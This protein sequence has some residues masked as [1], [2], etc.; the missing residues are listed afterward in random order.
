[1]KLYLAGGALALSLAMPLAAQAPQGPISRA[2]FMAQSK[3][4]FTALD[5]N[6]DGAITKDEVVAG[7]TK[8][9]R[10]APPPE[11]VDRL[12]AAI[13]TDSDGKATAGEVEKHAVERFDK[14]DTDH[15]GTLTAEE[16]AASQ[17]AMMAAQKPQ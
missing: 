10:S 9:F 7:M 13:D 1:M 11:I 12:F 8:M 4:Q 14:A 5:A 17:K 16:I 3:A 2:D 15:D 6:S